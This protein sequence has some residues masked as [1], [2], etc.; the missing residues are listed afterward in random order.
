MVGTAYLDMD[1]HRTVLFELI[2]DA[3]MNDKT[4]TKGAERKSKGREAMSF[5]KVRHQGTTGNGRWP[6]NYT[7]RHSFPFKRQLT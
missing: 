3:D 2:T 4:T 1:M 6:F 5:L 7:H